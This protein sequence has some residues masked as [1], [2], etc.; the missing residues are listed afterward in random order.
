[1]FLHKVQIVDQLDR[2]DWIRSLKVSFRYNDKNTL[3]LQIETTV[4]PRN[5]NER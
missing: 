2:G 4:S 1:M 5:N 3:R